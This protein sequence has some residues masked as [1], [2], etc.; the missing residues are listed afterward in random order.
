MNTLNQHE[1]ETHI[2]IVGILMIVSH[3]LYLV[4]AVILFGV[5][6]VMGGMLGGIGLASGDPEAARVLPTIAGGMAFLGILLAGLLG[7]L[8]LP[9]IIA[10]IGLLKRKAW[11]RLLA[12]VVAVLGLLHFPIGTF[13]GAYS[14]FVLLQDAA[15]NYFDGS[16]PNLTAYMN[17]A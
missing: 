8:S 14:I 12:L 17:P 3:A 10:G 4:A 5:L 11:A 15:P 2:P 13:I 16:K 6:T 9:G 1:L 7:M